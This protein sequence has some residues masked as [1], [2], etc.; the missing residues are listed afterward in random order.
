MTQIRKV[1]RSNRNTSL[2]AGTEAGTKGE[3]V[4]KMGQNNLYCG[5]IMVLQN[6]LS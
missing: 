5:K 6:W 2:T 4:E 3:E 1:P